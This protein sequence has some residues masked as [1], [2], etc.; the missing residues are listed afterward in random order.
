M[1]GVHASALTPVQALVEVCAGVGEGAP[2][3]DGGRAAALLLGFLRIVSSIVHLILSL[4]R[5]LHG[6]RLHS[7]TS[8]CI[9]RI[10]HSGQACVAHA[11]CNACQRSNPEGE[12]TPQTAPTAREKWCY[13]STVIPWFT[14]FSCLHASAGLQAGNARCCKAV[15]LAIVAV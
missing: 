6:Q 3:C 15:S 1:N 12:L 13:F 7:T 9:C 14:L 8:S 4:I 11:G 2:G 5:V 10:L